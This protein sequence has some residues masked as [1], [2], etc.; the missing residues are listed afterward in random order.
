MKCCSRRILDVTSVYSTQRHYV[1]FHYHR[2]QHPNQSI[3]HPPIQTGGEG[4]GGGA[5]NLYVDRLRDVVWEKRRVAEVGS[6]ILVLAPLPPGSHHVSIAVQG[7][8]I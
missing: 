8:G 7:H 4:G 6:V 2:L 1:F 3:E 5:A